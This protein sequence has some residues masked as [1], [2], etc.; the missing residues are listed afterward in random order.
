MEAGDFLKQKRDR[1][2]FKGKLAVAAKPA[3]KTLPS[4]SQTLIDLK[5]GPNSIVSGKYVAVPECSTTTGCPTS[6]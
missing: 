5:R 4:D 6:S 1:I 3:N 2:L